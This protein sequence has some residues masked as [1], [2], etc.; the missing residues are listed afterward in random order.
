[1][2]NACKSHTEY[3]N[4]ELVINERERELN[5]FRAM[6]YQLNAKPDSM[7]KAFSKRVIICRDDIIELNRLLNDKIKM[8]Y[9]DDGYIATI[10]INLSNKQLISFDCWEQFID[11]PWTENQ[12]INSIILKWNFNIRMPQ[13]EYPQNHTLMVKL[14]NGLRP[15]EMLNLIFSG[16]IEDFDEIETNTFPVAARVDFI[17]PILGEELLNIVSKWVNGLKHNRLK[18][19]V[20]VLFLQKYRKRV[21]QYFNYVTFIL[22][23]ILGAVLINKEMLSYKINYIEQLSI[24]QFLTFLN[25]IIFY[26]LF[27]FI[28]LR[29]FTVIAQKIYERLSVYGSGFVFSITKGDKEK[30]EDIKDKD[31]K[32]A[33]K[34]LIQFLFS[35]IFNVLCGVISGILI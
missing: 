4:T 28:S 29:F 10:T 33:K 18:K 16:N 13:Y 31:D 35:I 3:D 14:T 22:I 23:T 27:L 8:L 12:C 24:E 30:Q 15:E 11:Y 19:N 17:H 20:F 6:Y 34:I 26:I 25:S 32:N 21:A 9:Q 2:D 1:M 5:L 7:S